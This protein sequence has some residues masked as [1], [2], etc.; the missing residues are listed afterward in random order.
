MFNAENE[1]RSHIRT[2]SVHPC[3]IF[4]PRSGKY[5]HGT[6]CDLSLG[7]A[8]IRINRPCTLQPGDTLHIGI[9]LGDRLGFMQARD[10]FEAT[11]VRSFGTPSGQTM[12]AIKS[13]AT[14][15]PLQA[16]LPKAA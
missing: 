4:D 11:V 13:E 15:T 5:L 7:G 12:V 2:E 9:A 16:I 10:M 3:R 14:T 6:T 8:L 1:Q